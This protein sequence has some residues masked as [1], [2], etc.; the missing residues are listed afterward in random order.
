MGQEV[1]VAGCLGVLRD[2]GGLVFAD[3]RDVSG[4][5]QVVLPQGDT[6]HTTSTHQPPPPERQSK[7]PSENRVHR[8]SRCDGL[9]HEYRNAA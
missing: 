1:R 8:A 6:D 5:V 7:R 9:I 3:I 4:V 2:H